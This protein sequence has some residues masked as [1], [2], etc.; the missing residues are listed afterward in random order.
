MAL[1]RST[2][3][4]S[5]AS[6]ATP[7]DGIA[8]ANRLICGDASAGMFVTLF[9]AQLDP[10]TAELTYVNA[11]HNPAIVC[12]THEK[13][14]RWLERTGLI[15]GVDDVAVYTQRTIRLEPGDFVVLYTDGVID[16]VHDDAPDE[17]F[18]EERL[19][20]LL[21]AHRHEP[22]A[23]IVAALEDALRDFT[24]PALPFDDVAIVAIKRL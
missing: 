19:Y 23:Q 14:C 9:Y 21:A 5:L 24:G 6:A 18:G 2:V 12:S 3:R 8:S 20:E 16:A 15:L 13:E 10:S 17:C 4:A 7:A 1:T 11:G 22:M